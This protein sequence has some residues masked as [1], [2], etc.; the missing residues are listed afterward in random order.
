MIANT[1]LRARYLFFRQ[2]A[3]GVGI[4]SSTRPSLFEPFGSTLRDHSFI[5]SYDYENNQ[6]THSLSRL[7]RF[8]HYLIRLFEVV[9]SCPDYQAVILDN[10][11]NP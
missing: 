1:S 11:P 3:L 10:Q 6:P 2:A 7:L 9:Q 4:P 8:E 5:H